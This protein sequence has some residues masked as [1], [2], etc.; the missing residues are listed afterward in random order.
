MNLTPDSRDR[1]LE[2]VLKAHKYR[3]TGLNTQT[4]L[5]LIDQEASSP[6]L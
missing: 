2:R 3:E 5:D 1:L 4:V 6:N